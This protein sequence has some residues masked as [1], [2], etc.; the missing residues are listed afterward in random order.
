MNDN[1]FLKAQLEKPPQNS[2]KWRAMMIGAKGVAGFF[3]ITMVM[4][5]FQPTLAS[6]LTTL[7][8][9]A[10]TAWGGLFGIFM[11]ATG[12]V[13]YKTTAA[14]QSSVVDEHREE[15]VTTRTEGGA[16]AHGHDDVP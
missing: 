11:G 13:D 10:V 15:I 5:M 12:A 8:Q 2:K 1:S 4:I 9:F 6:Q 7:F 14:L 16:K 3:L